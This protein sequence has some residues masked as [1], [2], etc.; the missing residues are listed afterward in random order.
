ML[1]NAAVTMRCLIGSLTLGANTPIWSQGEIFVTTEFYAK[2][3]ER[4]K[5]AERV[6]VEVEVKK[7]IPS[8]S[9]KKKRKEN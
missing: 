9:S 3:F 1:E 4:E 5:L 8:R 6:E 2:V 7:E